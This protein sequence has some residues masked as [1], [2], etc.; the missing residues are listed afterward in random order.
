MIRGDR[1]E[2]RITLP[3]VVADVASLEERFDLIL[4]AVKWPELEQACDPLPN[5]I[6]PLGVVVPLLNGLTS[7]DVV[8]HYVGAQRTLAA[9]A[10]MSAGIASPGTLYVQGQPRL[11]LAAYRPGQDADLER[12]ASLFE[13]A[14]VRVMRSSDYRQMLW[15]K[16]VWNAPFNAL[17]ALTNKPAGVC[18]ERMEPLILRAMREVL[19]VAAAEGVSI[20]PQL[21]ERMLHTSR[22]EYAETVPSMLQDVRKGRPTEA[23]PLQGEVVARAERLGVDAPVLSTLA[24]LMR[25]LA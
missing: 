6:T 24:S 7:E 18:I 14:G 15:E 20:S 12:V 9:V 1:G 13:R 17:C 5:L 25:G 4:L 19:A 23:D 22:L 16:M 2:E 8:A 11:G 3:R 10:Y 21:P